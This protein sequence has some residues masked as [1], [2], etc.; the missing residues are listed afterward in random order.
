MEQRKRMPRPG[1]R[2]VH[3]FRKR[4]GQVVAEVVSVDE[5]TGRVTVR[6]GDKLYPSLSAA[7]LAVSGRP[8]IGW[9]YWGLKKQMQGYRRTP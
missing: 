3:G 2:L 5:R 1:D 7:A 6:I 8:S 9:V 4:G